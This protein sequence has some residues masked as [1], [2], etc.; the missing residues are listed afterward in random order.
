[1]ISTIGKNTFT[2]TPSFTHG[3]ITLLIQNPAAGD[4]DLRVINMLGQVMQHHFVTLDSQS[5]LTIDLSD[6]SPG[7]YILFS[8]IGYDY[9]RNKVM[10]QR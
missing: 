1:M 5:T 6:L 10:V 2:V 3:P 8:K 7:V 9:V 4:M